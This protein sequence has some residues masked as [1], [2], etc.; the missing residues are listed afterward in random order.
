[1]DL[2]KDSIEEKS[3]LKAK[4]GSTCKDEKIR[5]TIETLKD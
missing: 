5:G 4:F 1:V 3:S 2:N